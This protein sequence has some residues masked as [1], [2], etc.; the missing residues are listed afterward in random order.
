M[1]ALN[2]AHQAFRSGQVGPLGWP[3]TPPQ[4]TE[5]KVWAVGAY[6]DRDPV[7]VLDRLLARNRGTRAFWIGRT[8]SE[9]LSGNDRIS[10]AGAEPIPLEGEWDAVYIYN[11]QGSGGA[12]DLDLQGR[13][14]VKQNSGNVGVPGAGEFVVRATP[15]ANATT[16][17]TVYAR[18]KITLS[19]VKTWTKVPAFGAACTMAVAGPG[20]NLLSAANI[21]VAGLTTV[22]YQS[23]TLTGT[24]S[25]LDLNPGDPVTITIVGGVGLTPGDLLVALGWA[26]R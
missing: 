19:F 9:V 8:L 2:L 7:N 18:A 26:F 17:F 22:T 1:P 24:T 25:R 12:V 6:G 4:L 13:Q 3:H 23:A 20:G 11:P 16:V 14:L 10:I 15:V 5:G 21:S